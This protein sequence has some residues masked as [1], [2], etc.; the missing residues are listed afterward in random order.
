MLVTKKP[1]DR[2]SL[3]AALDGCEGCHTFSLHK[4]EVDIDGMTTTME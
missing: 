2:A 3:Q 1:N 4:C